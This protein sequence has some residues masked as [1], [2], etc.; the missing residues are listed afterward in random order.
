MPLPW[1]VFHSG[2]NERGLAQR[3]VFAGGSQD[4]AHVRMPS[5]LPC[6]KEVRLRLPYATVG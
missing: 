3:A 2:L 1:A 6:V 5:H 4:L